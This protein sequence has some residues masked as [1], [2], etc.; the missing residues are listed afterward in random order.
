ME[1]R[2]N[3]APGY[4][5]CHLWELLFGEVERMVERFDPEFGLIQAGGQISTQDGIVHDIE[6][7]SD[8]VPA[9]II[10]PDLQ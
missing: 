9:L 7:P 3:C 10:E 6:E 4:L 5:Q 2:M 1:W 8:T